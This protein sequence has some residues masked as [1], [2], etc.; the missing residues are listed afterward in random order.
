MEEA[1]H[2]PVHSVAE[3]A[4]AG[5][6]SLLRADGDGDGAVEGGRRRMDGGNNGAV[7]DGGGDGAVEGGHGVPS[8]ER[9]SE[10]AVRSRVLRGRE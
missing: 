1:R 7:E 4:G 5:D 3:C 6:A 9:S 8:R 10:G 2:P